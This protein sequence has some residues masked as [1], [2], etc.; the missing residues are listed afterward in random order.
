MGFEHCV[1]NQFLLPMAVRVRGSKLW[2]P[3]GTWAQASQSHCNRRAPAD[4]PLMHVPSP[5]TPTPPAPPSPQPRP[6]PAPQISLGAPLSAHDVIVGNL[7]PTTLGNWVGGA[8]F[9]GT[10]YAFAYGTPNRKISEW[11]SR[12]RK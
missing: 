9:V 6:P 8:F 7:I 11:W 12:Q 4:K 2:R 10:T 5:P 3:P 1:A